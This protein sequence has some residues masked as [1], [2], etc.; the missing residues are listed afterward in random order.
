MGSNAGVIYVFGEFLIWE[1]VSDK[2]RFVGLGSSRFQN[3]S[4]QVQIQLAA[5]IL[6][7]LVRLDLDSRARFLGPPLAP[8]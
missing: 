3:N 5:S 4:I 2:S 7:V 8:L 6:M 1:F